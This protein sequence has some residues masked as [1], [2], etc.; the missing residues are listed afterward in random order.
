MTCKLASGFFQSL[1]VVSSTHRRV[2]DLSRV[3]SY[4]VAMISSVKAISGNAPATGSISVTVFGLEFG[5]VDLSEILKFGSTRCMSTTFVSD[6][7]LSCKV[8]AGSAQ[9]SKR[10]CG[11]AVATASTTAATIARASSAACCLQQRQPGN[12]HA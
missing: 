1:S 6:T 11:N 3:F 7:S 4:D 12:A 2:S 5:T 10:R 9:S 8:S